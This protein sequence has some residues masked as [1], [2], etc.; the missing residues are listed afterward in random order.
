MKN[1]IE[2]TKKNSKKVK[3]SNLIFSMKLFG[4]LKKALITTSTLRTTMKIK[5]KKY[6]APINYI[7][8]IM[9]T[10]KKTALVTKSAAL[11]RFEKEVDEKTKPT[12]VS[13]K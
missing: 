2:K 7:S 13:A 3:E 1:L 4:T 12:P 9:K 11:E 8:I 5:R 10:K 6:T